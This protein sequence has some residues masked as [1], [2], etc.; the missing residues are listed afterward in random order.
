MKLKVYCINLKE[1]TLKKE[2]ITKLLKEEGL[3]DIALMFDGVHY[4]EIN[5]DFL[6]SNDLK[7]FDE[8]G[9]AHV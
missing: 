9:R 2:R 5:E 1:E 7:I 4:S 3:S 6:K 8:I